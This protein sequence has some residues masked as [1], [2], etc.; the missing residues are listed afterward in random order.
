MNNN[1]WSLMSIVCAL[2]LALSFLGIVSCAGAGRMAAETAPIVVAPAISRG[3][4]DV[5]VTVGE[6]ARF[7][8]VVTGTDPLSYVW[9]KSSNGRVDEVG[10]AKSYTT[11]ATLMA[12]NSARFSVVVTNAAGQADSREATLTVTDSAEFSVGFSLNYSGAPSAPVVQTIAQGGKVTEPSAP[13]R[14]SFTFGGWYQEATCTTAWN[15]ATHT[16]TA[17]QIL[18]AKWSAVAPPGTTSFSA[19]HTVAKESILRSIPQSAIDSAKSNLRIAYFHTSHGSRVI[20]G[21]AGLLNYKSGDAAKWAFT[22]DGSVVAGKLSIDDHYGDFGDLST[23]EAVVNGHTQWYSA[24]EA[25][26]DDPAHSHINVVMWSWCDPG[27]HDH[28]R[29]IS[30]M[31]ALI[32]GY[33]NVKFVFMTGHPNGDGEASGSSAYHCHDLVS[34]HCLQNHLFVLDYWDIETHGMDETY[35]PNANDNGVSGSIDFYSNWM[36]A[37]GLGTDYFDCSCAHATQPITGNRI[38]Y[39]SWWL[40]ARLAGWNG[41]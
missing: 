40:W 13:T 10:H 21:M 1:G 35:F 4:A 8:V 6:T 27:G 25:Y 9:K 37:H 32:S 39:A 5:A 33:P 30:N 41:Q 23:Q 15:F 26:L 17:N 12:D 18:Y 31:E 38:A 24:T 19:D 36:N 2:L 7:D 22:S 11:P 20:D 14:T 16:V 34:T 29:Y 28:Q 3:P